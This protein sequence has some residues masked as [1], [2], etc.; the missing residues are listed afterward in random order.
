VA[1]REKLPWDARYANCTK[2]ILYLLGDQG[3]GNIR[4]TIGLSGPVA[5]KRM[6][7]Q[8]FVSKNARLEKPDRKKDAPW[9]TAKVV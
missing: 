7:A 6:D 3:N 5:A 8:G 1:A 2:C 4:T 9:L